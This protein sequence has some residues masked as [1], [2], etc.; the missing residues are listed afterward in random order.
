VS[1]NCSLVQGYNTTS[2]NTG[3]PDSIN[4]GTGSDGFSQPFGVS[5][6]DCRPAQ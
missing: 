6:Y 3:A 2:K 4:G 1:S 5:L